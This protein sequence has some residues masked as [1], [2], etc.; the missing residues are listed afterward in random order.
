VKFEEFGVIFDELF[1][2]YA[3]GSFGYVFVFFVVKLIVVRLRNDHWIILSD[4]LDNE[5]L[6]LEFPEVV[7]IE[8]HYSR[9]DVRD[10]ESEADRAVLLLEDQVLVWVGLL[11]LVDF[12][13]AFSQKVLLMKLP[14][15]CSNYLVH[16]T[17]DY[18]APIGGRSPFDARPAEPL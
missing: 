10:D 8:C 15:S 6:S 11:G 14:L 16:A 2:V 4:V 3:M 5:V 1:D 12:L 18:L 9:V 17:E 7:F 13:E